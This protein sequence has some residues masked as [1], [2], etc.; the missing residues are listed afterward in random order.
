MYNIKQHCSKATLTLSKIESAIEGFTHM[1]TL[2][3][4]KT[5]LLM[6]GIGSDNKRF[7]AFYRPINKHKRTKQETNN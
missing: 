1:E 5:Q 2:V 7:V 6:P 4:I 3:N